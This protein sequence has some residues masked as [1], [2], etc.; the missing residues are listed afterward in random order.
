[1]GAFRL[2]LGRYLSLTALRRELEGW[3][4]EA[5]GENKDAQPLQTIPGIGSVLA[6]IILAEAGD[7]R[8]FGHHRQFLKFRGLDLAKSQSGVSRGRETSSKRGN[9]RLRC[10]FWMA[11]A[12]AVRMR[13]NSFRD[14]YERY[15]KPDPLDPDL[16]RKAL[17]AVMAK[18][19][20]V[21]CG[22]VKAQT[23]Y[24]TYR[25]AAVPVDRSRSA[26]P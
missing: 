22:I 14:K 16:R 24:R 5:I 20:R 1:M 13:Q 6:L 10:A 17:A 2:Q 9:R 11:G 15:I 26:G 23:P 21:A 25:E 19:A 12:V 7:L 4:Q 3:A 8:R 18:M